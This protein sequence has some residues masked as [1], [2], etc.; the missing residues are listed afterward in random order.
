MALDESRG[1]REYDKFVADGSG[2]ASVRV[3]TPPSVPPSATAGSGSTTSGHATGTGTATPTSAQTEILAATDV[4]GKERISIQIFNTGTSSSPNTQDAVYKV[5]GTL[6][7][8]P[9][10][11]GGAN[12]TQIGDDITIE[13]ASNAYKAIATTPIK[14]IGV[15][16]H[17][18]GSA[19][20]DAATTTNIYL[21]AD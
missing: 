13:E 1:K 7:T 14:S 18:T 21:M 8:T 19:G 11:A 5:W 2:D 6:I 16:G 10:T 9:G 4:E 12:W 20:T 17:A 3:T 15:T